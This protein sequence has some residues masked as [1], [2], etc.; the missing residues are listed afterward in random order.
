MGGDEVSFSCWNT[1]ESLKT[2][3]TG[4]DWDLGSSGFVKSWG[5]F[6]SSALAR[7]DKLTEKRLPII[8]WM[9]TLTDEPNL[10]EHLDK[11]RYIIQV[12]SYA[13][14]PRY[15]T[16]LE[17]GF[18]MIVSNYDMHYLDCGFSGWVDDGHNWCSPY[19]GWQKIY[20][21]TMESIGGQYIDQ[22]LGAE[23][24]LW[25]EQT[26]DQALDSRIWPRAAALAERLWTSKSKSV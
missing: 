18:K 4:Q 26:D 12:W 5:H 6:Q 13:V 17:N 24:P 19:H 14:D 15:Q 9:S 11:D 21:F 16:I 20:D 2:W 7:L 8:L 1:S 3:M 23:S 25:T 22:I 10:I